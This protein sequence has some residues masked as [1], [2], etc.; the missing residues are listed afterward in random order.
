MRVD[1]ACNLVVVVWLCVATFYSR[2]R[3]ELSAATPA[4]L[5][6]LFLC[7]VCLQASQRILLRAGIVSTSLN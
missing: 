5:E 2:L 4:V 1:F 3:L 6:P 7:C